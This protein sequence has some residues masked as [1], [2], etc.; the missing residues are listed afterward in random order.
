MAQKTNKQ[1]RDEIKETL[2]LAKQLEQEIRSFS[3][4]SETIIGRT[5]ASL[6]GFSEGI[7]KNLQ[8]TSRLGAREAN[9]IHS[10]M[11]SMVQEIQTGFANAVEI[12]NKFSES[13]FKEEDV[14]E[15]ESMIMSPFE[16][17]TNRIKMLPLGNV[18]QKILGLDAAKNKII[19]NLEIPIVKS[20]SS[21]RIEWKSFS[22]AGSTALKTI[23]SKVL[24][25]S[26]AL[27]GISFLLEKAW[28]RF[29]EIDE[30]II[31]LRQN[32]GLYGKQ[33]MSITNIIQDSSKELSIYGI[34]T[35][36]IAS[37][38]TDML[39]S[40]QNMALVNKENVELLTVMGQKLG[41]QVKT[42]SSVLNIFLNLAKGNERIARSLALSTLE[43]S[44][45][46]N[47][48]PAAVFSD[49]E[50]SSEKIFEYM[51]GTPDVI[52]KTAVR[53]R[54][55]GLNLNTVLGITEKLLSFESS[56]E[57]EMTAMVL[58]GKQLNLGQARYYA[59]LGETDKQLDEI[60][61]QVMSIGDFS[62]ML[63]YEQKAYADAVGL[64]V[65]ELRTLV[66]NQELLNKT[67]DGTTKSYE[68]AFK[69][70]LTF[71]QILKDKNILTPFEELNNS[72]KAMVVQIAD[73]LLPL[74]KILIPAIKGL[75]SGILSGIKVLMLPFN[76]LSSAL[77]AIGIE[78]NSIGNIFE[79]VFKGIGALISAFTITY[80]IKMIPAAI[81]FIGS[82]VSGLGAL[83]TTIGT[84]ISIAFGPVT[85]IV[86]AIAALGAAI[87]LTI[88]Y[89][90]EIS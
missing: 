67:V 30:S 38:T 13:V 20:L 43:A 70:G 45:L 39:D 65:G 8:M 59:L 18:L 86:L 64:S 19:Q 41:I 36:D 53:A 6:S 52:S 83:L 14:E 42:G 47:V 2:D 11:K 71:N 50:Q 9:R 28:E 34:Q 12:S 24:L 4:D 72:F 46:A 75:F 89:W 29:K 49:I 32:T 10:S 3:E 68:D 78:A 31:S 90:D 33:L 60:V 79:V 37:T 69:G 7:V 56:I 77:K 81:A 1:I 63:P 17:V 15:I 21:G 27:A 5:F 76:L 61:K 87:A 85:L 35:H 44:K 48:A 54:Q 26:A 51:N 16:S 66:R 62:K 57:S 74:F 25:F 80:L 55:L 23:G 88:T 22:E 82:A 40:F 84:T 58:T 73:S